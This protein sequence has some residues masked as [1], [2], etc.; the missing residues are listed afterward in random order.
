MT[1]RDIYTVECVAHGARW[2]ISVRVPDGDLTKAEVCPY[3][4]LD[5]VGLTVAD[6]LSLLA[7]N[8]RTIN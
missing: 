6:V 2:L 8:F 1:A 4:R 3:S 7:P 5:L